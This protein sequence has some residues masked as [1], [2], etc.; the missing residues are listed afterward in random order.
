M[1]YTKGIFEVG[2]SES[3]LFSPEA[4]RILCIIWKLSQCQDVTSEIRKM[5]V[6]YLQCRSFSS[7]LY[8][9]LERKRMAWGLNEWSEL[10]QCSFPSSAA[11]F[12]PLGKSLHFWCP[13]VWFSLP[14]QNLASSHC[15]NTKVR[16]DADTPARRICFQALKYSEPF[17][18]PVPQV[19]FSVV[20]WVVCLKNAFPL[21]AGLFLSSNTTSALH[22][23]NPKRFGFLSS[24]F[25]QI[26]LTV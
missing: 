5:I 26:V 12:Q 14:A 24:D 22:A 1:N 17:F 19:M 15:C 8:K 23:A 2:C 13:G 6:M 9:E 25:E 18:I 10:H 4:S 16:L 3:G 21:W 11:A 20:V 7:R